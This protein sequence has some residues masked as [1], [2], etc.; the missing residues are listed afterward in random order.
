MKY[1]LCTALLA[2]AALFASASSVATTRDA[3]P[4][5]GFVKLSYLAQPADTSPLL[6]PAA[7]QAQPVQLASGLPSCWN[8][9]GNYCPTVGVSIRCQ[10][11]PYE[12]GR[13][14]CRTGN[15]WVCG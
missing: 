14:G 2:V 7:N 15:V 11:Q 8:Y 1:A 10:W 4:A 5:P 6:Q 12:P 13:C 9:D 3:L